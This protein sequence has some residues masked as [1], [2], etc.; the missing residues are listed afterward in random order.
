MPAEAGHWAAASEPVCDC[1]WPHYPHYN[2]LVTPAPAA[3]LDS[4]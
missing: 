4:C 2:Q 1:V 3:D